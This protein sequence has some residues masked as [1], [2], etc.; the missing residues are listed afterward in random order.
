MRSG[1][2][3]LHTQLTT[4]PEAAQ[5]PFSN[6]GA[7][8]VKAVEFVDWFSGTFGD[9]VPLEN[10]HR[11]VGDR[12]WDELPR[13]AMGYARG[14]KSGGVWL[15]YDGRPGMGSHLVMGGEACREL[16][17]RG[18]IRDWREWAAMALVLGVSVSRLDLARDDLSGVLDLDQLAEAWVAGAVTSRWN[19]DARDIRDL[20]KGGGRGRRAPWEKPLITTGRTLHFGSGQSRAQCRIYD[21]AQELAG[22]LR[23]EERAAFLEEHGPHVRVEMQLRDKRAEAAFRLLAT[24]GLAF[25]PGLVRSYLDFKAYDTE[26]HDATRVPTLPA[27]EAF[28]SAAAKVTLATEVPERTVETVAG[29]LEHQWA[30][31]LATL[32]TAWGGDVS[33]VHDIIRAGLPRMRRKHYELIARHRSAA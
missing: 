8:P 4:G 17:A 25:L 7:Q 14:R 22:K 15:F 16:E 10:W 12:D 9:G 19:R 29:S 5:P 31:M 32:V 21:K 20:P 11:L 28:L 2:T 6:T 1:G 24:H 23:G 27:W 30:P 18:I 3:Y 26:G 33:Q 13:G